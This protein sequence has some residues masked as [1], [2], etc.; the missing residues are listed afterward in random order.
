MNIKN[1]Q[2]AADPTTDKRMKGADENRQSDKLNNAS[3]ADLNNP[4]A[5]PPEASKAKL[6]DAAEKSAEL[7][8][9]E[10]TNDSTIDPNKPKEK[11]LEGFHGG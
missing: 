6:R 8:S 4:S 9:P 1:S 7:D 11:I 2:E 10:R 5:E 3:P